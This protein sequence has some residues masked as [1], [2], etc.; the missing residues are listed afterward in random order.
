MSKLTYPLNGLLTSCRGEIEE[1]DKQLREAATSCVF[2]VPLDFPY[3]SYLNE[4][5]FNISKYRSEL[6]ALRYKMQSLDKSYASL[7]AELEH[8]A[9]KIVVSEIKPREG[10]VR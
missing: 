3:R 4:L 2:D 5:N 1:C 6:D 10:I 7:S 9:S 8:S